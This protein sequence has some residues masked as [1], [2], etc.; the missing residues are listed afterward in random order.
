MQN[1]R[2]LRPVDV[3][4]LNDSVFRAVIR[5]YEILFAIMIPIELS[6]TIAIAHHRFPQM[7]IAH[8]LAV[9]IPFFLTAFF[10]HF[11]LGFIGVMFLV[12][13][14]SLAWW[15]HVLAFG[16]PSAA[17]TVLAVASRRVV[18]R[19][20]QPSIPSVVAGLVRRDHPLRS[21]P[22]HPLL[23][24]LRCAL[25]IS[26]TAPPGVPI[27]H[28]DFFVRIDQLISRRIA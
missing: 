15:R 1:W 5:F 7:S 22:E 9:A 2:A 6:S 20:A 27:T 8:V 11:V 10:T 24:Q 17:L 18:I 28:A 13:V 26:S 3:A 19:L 25:S 4:R 23:D 12:A 21:V 16:G 14:G